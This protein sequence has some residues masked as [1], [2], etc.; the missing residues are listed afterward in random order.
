MSHWF[1]NRRRRG[2]GRSDY[3]ACGAILNITYAI[4]S[5]WS[6]NYSGSEIDYFLLSLYKALYLNEI[7]LLVFDNGQNIRQETRFLNLYPL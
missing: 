1:A 2:A 7:Y 4:K 6:T 5:W 3:D